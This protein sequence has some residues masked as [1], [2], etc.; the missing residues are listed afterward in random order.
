MP[1]ELSAKLSILSLRLTR[2]SMSAAEANL[3]LAVATTGVPGEVRAKYLRGQ[4]LSTIQAD[5]HVDA[6]GTAALELHAVVRVDLTYKGDMVRSS[7]RTRKRLTTVCRIWHNATAPRPSSKNSRGIRRVGRSE[8][9]TR[10]AASKSTSIGSSGTIGFHMKMQ[11]PAYRPQG[12]Q[13]RM[14]SHLPQMVRDL[15]RFLSDVQRSVSQK[16]LR[17]RDEELDDLA[18][19]LVDFAADVH[20]GTGIWGSYERYNVDLFGTPLPLTADDNLPES[21]GGIHQERV[22]HFLWVAYQKLSNAAVLSPRNEDLQRLADATS[23]FLHD[24]FATL[25]QDSGI[26]AFLA[27]PNTYGW[28]V[29]RKLVWLGTKSYMFRLFFRQYLLQ[30]CGGKEDITHTDDFICQQC[31]EWSGL[32]AVDI[33]AGVL[34]ISDDDR[35]T[36]RSWYERHVAPYLILSAKTDVVKA[37]NTINDQE[38]VIRINMKNHPFVAG[39][40][41]IG[42]LTPWRG[43][44]YWSGTQRPIKD[45]PQSLLA[46]LKNTM[47]R[48]SSG[49][50]YRYDRERRQKAIERMAALHAEALAFYGKDLIVYP[51]GLSMAADWQRELHQNWARQPPEAVRE[52][53]EKHGLKHSRPDIAIPKGLLESKNGVGVFLNPD[54][55]EIMELFNSVV[56]G[57]R[58]NGVGLTEDEEQAIRAFLRSRDIS[59]RFV[60]RMVRDSGEESIKAS[61]RLGETSASCWLDYLLRR[62]KGSFFRRCHPPLSIT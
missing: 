57:L 43:E 5:V 44:W 23:S 59:P 31:T 51:D 29:K 11:Y 49:L 12:Y 54:G 41:V 35:K 50:V 34:D 25:P 21:L 16:C 61:F 52:I 46:D 33:L 15:H 18:G 56:S 26:K 2:K 47:I 39:L 6:I 30:E 14:D 37:R 48:R 40:L 24:K 10:I 1:D 4:G 19:I 53:V 38:Y 60:R 9:F 13:G 45:P 22:R 36:L 8:A 17:F 20:G 58:R 32:G 7:G 28:D 62:H 27:T 55:R 3:L 42:S